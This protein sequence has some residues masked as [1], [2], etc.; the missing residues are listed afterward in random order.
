[1]L[2]LR[3]SQKSRVFNTFIDYKVVLNISEKY[4]LK[5]INK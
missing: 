2:V 4:R 5:K 1:M 3:V